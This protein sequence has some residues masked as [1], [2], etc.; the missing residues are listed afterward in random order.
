MAIIQ[1]VD[2]PKPRQNETLWAY[3]SWDVDWNSKPALSPVL[4]FDQFDFFTLVVNQG[5]R[6]RAQAFLEELADLV[7][8][9]PPGALKQKWDSGEEE[10][11]N[12]LFD[13]ERCKIILSL[14]EDYLSD[15]EGLRES[16]RSVMRNRFRIQ[17][18]NGE[19]A[20][21]VIV[22]PVPGLVDD[23][24]AT[25]LVQLV[26][27]SGEPGRDSP[28][29]KDQLKELEIEPALLSLV[30]RE[31]N[32]QRIKNEQLTITTDLLQDSYHDILKTFYAD[33]MANL[34]PE[35]R[36]FVEDRL[37]TRSG[38]RTSVALED[39]LA[40]KG[41][42]QEIINRLVKRRLLRIE[43]RFNVP[44]VELTHDILTTEIRA[45]RDARQKQTAESALAAER[46]RAER[47]KHQAEAELAA[48]RDRAEREKRQA[49]EELAA[50]KTRAARERKKT[51]WALIAL[52]VA[53]VALL[54]AAFLGLFARYA[55][56][57]K[58]A[59]LVETQKTKDDVVEMLGND[60]FDLRD[61][62][63]AINRLDMMERMTDNTITNL[64]KF[65]GHEATNT[66]L[67][68]KGVA[69][70][71]R[72][73]ISLFHDGKLT[74]AL[75]PYAKSL[76]IFTS[77]SQRVRTNSDYK[78]AVANETSRI[79]DVKSMQ[80]D[81]KDAAQSYNEVLAM[82][83]GLVQEKEPLASWFTMLASIRDRVADNLQAQG[84]LSE[85][86]T[87]YRLSLVERKRRASL[88]ENDDLQVENT[89]EDN[90]AQEKI[91]DDDR[92][93]L[94]Q[95]YLQIGIVLRALGNLSQSLE[96]QQKSLAFRKELGAN[97]SNL[98]QQHDLSQSYD[99]VG[100]ALQDAGKLDEAN[101]AF[102]KSEDIFEKLHELDPDNVDWKRNFSVTLVRLANL[103]TLIGKTKLAAETNAWIVEIRETL[104]Q[105][106]ETNADAKGDLT[107]AYVNMGD[108]WLLCGDLDESAQSYEKAFALASETAN[109]D[110]TNLDRQE[111]LAESL[112]KL[113]DI[114]LAQGNPDGALQRYEN[115]TEIR[116]NLASQDPSN[117]L[118]Q[119]ELARS[120]QKVGEA[121]RERGNSTSALDAFQGSVAALE[122]LCKNDPSNAQWQGELA[123][124]SETSRAETG[125][126]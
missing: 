121:H 99:R 40:Q 61:K 110:V 95:S 35:V 25:R 38:Y 88:P 28:P 47:E 31:L 66:V 82:L 56:S 30:C 41:M 120:N 97:S 113:G 114:S 62:L 90:T 29:T 39:A 125:A 42:T 48:Q 84:K 54:I 98:Y 123:G 50:E 13:R 18:M 5:R 92:S 57:K 23:D 104:A 63:Q 17:P 112:E 52:S 21:K 109:R 37:L 93:D 107:E 86:L 75:E 67:Y 44:A 55:L 59:A 69:F 87:L 3:L 20:F 15:L 7:E 73:D 22:A 2:A 106:D 91:D 65:G 49:A 45:S 58:K 101:D 10:V 43:D 81:L 122:T 53:V 14:R 9:R 1:G 105:I 32:A 72:G 108:S 119:F 100:E 103:T 78:L 36:Y 89:Q 33:S 46:E 64:E 11:T 60:L 26:A 83:Q 126:K 76:A 70:E 96:Y 111:L 80:G 74:A 34:P 19:N 85:A 12:F 117:A 71:I 6:E 8:R 94:A 4:V 116:V 24:V 27:H 77:L 51:L 68:T 118:R 79:A 115:S 124:R 102:S 16:M